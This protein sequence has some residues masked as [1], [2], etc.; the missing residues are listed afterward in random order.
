VA[1][2]TITQKNAAASV[3]STDEI[4]IWQPAGPG[5]SQKKAT[6]AQLMTWGAGRGTF[7]LAASSTST[8]VTDA[9]C[10]ATSVILIM[11][12]TTHAAAGLTTTSIA[13]GVGSFVVSHANNAYVDR[14]FSYIII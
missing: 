5:G 3:D 14:T 7:T 2:F 4:P 12:Q 6:V 8:T 9:R 10:V 13:P 1:T 11:P